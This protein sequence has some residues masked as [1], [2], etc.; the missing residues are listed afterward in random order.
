MTI[1]DCKCDNSHHKRDP[2]KRDLIYFIKRYIQEIFE[3]ASGL[4]VLYLITR[5]QK[6]DVPFQ[7]KKFFFAA[8][9]IGSVTLVLEEYYDETHA[10]NIKQ[11]LAF[12]IGASALRGF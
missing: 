5:N 12:T 4:F 10:S 3:A 7:Y 6:E 2:P 9:I 11:G 1:H 8:C